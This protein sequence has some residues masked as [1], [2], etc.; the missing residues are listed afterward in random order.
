MLFCGHKY[1]ESG[2]ERNGGNGGNSGGIEFV[3]GSAC[4]IIR[5]REKWIRWPVCV[6]AFLVMDR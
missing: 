6:G 1:K 5:C 3:F 2:A 4:K